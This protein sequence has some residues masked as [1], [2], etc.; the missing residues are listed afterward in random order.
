[1]A[2]FFTYLINHWQ[3]TAHSLPTP[4]MLSRQN[5]KYVIRVV[6]FHSSIIKIVKPGYIMLNF[7]QNTKLTRLG[8]N[9]GIELQS[10]SMEFLSRFITNAASLTNPSADYIYIYVRQTFS[11][12]CF[13]ADTLAHSSAKPSAGTELTEKVPESKVHGANMG[14]IWG[15][16]DPGGPHVGPKNF[17]IWDV[18]SSILCCP[19]II[20]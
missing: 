9:H 6:Y 3:N 2:S 18:F 17:V 8:E 15:R 19:T 16:Q 5:I 14:P 12:P 1:M 7:M 11:H 4:K 20:Q 10:C 13:P